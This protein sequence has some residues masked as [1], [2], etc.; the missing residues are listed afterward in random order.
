M[1]ISNG[2]GGLTTITNNGA[3]GSALDDLAI[4]VYGGGQVVM[5]NTGSVFGRVAFEAST[6]GNTFTNAG[7]I[8]GGVSLGA[9]T[10][11]RFNAVTGSQL[12]DLHGRQV[13]KVTRPEGFNIEFAEDG[14]V[15]GGL[16][17]FNTL[18]LQNAV[19]GGSGT[20]GTG[21]IAAAAYVNFQELLVESGTWTID[22]ALL[23]GAT[24]RTTL[25]GGALSVNNDNFAGSGAILATGGALTT[26]AASLILA[27]N[28][29]LGV[30]ATQGSNGLNLYGANA[31]TLDGVISGAAGAT[32][33]KN[34]SG[35]LRLNGVNSYAGGTLLNGGTTFVGN[36]SAFGSGSLTIGTG[37]A[38]VDSSGVIT[39][40]NA[41][42][43]GGSLILD[44]SHD[45]ALA[46]TISGAGAL[47]K[48]GNGNLTL[49]AANSYQGGTSLGA[50]SLTLAHDAALGTGTLSVS[51]TSSLFTTGNRQLGNAVAIASQLTFDGSYDLALNGGLSGS[52]ELVKNGNGQLLLGSASA[53]TGTTRVNAGSMI[54][55]GTFASAQVQVA[56]GADLIFQQDGYGTFAGAL[57]GTGEA[58]KRGAGT[59]LMTGHS[60]FSGNFIVQ[61]GTLEMGQAVTPMASV[62]RS[63]LLAAPVGGAL[64]ANVVV[65]SGARLSG[66]G[67][68]G[69]LVNSGTVQPG[70]NGNLTVS[71]DFTN[72]SNGTLSINLTQQPTSYL[73]VG[74]TANLGGTLNLFSLGTSPVDTSYTLLTADGG[75]I[76]TFDTL[77]VASE[78]AFITAS[79]GYG[80]NDLTLSVVRNGVALA[81]V[82]WSRN[83]VGVATALDSSAAPA[84][85]RNQV[86]GLSATSARS[87]F[88]ALSGEIHA[89]T[90][91]VLI[92]DSRYV[93]DTVNERMRQGGCPGDARSVLAPS[94]DL[95][96]SSA[97][98]QGE[99]VGWMRALGG[100]GDYDS[101]HAA[102]SVDRDL[103]GFMLGFDNNLNE[104]WRAGIAAGY[105][106][107]SIKA[108]DRGSDASVD[109]Y[110]LATYLSYQMDAFA[111]RL[112]AAY[113]WHD[114]DSKREVAVGSY[115]DRL[116]AGYKAG[117]AQVFGEVGYTLQAAGVAVEPF[118]GIAWV[119]YDSDTAREKGGDA[120]LEASAKQDVTFTTVG[121]R[122]GKQF[123]LDN[124][125]TV[126]PRGSIGWRHALGDTTPDADM[127]F[128]DGGAAFSVQ[129]APIAR[130]AAVV[131][132]GLDVGVG[133]SGKLGLGYSGQLASGNRDHAVTVSFSLGF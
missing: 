24:T 117:S 95:Q 106:N 116:K 4:A 107:S 98:C 40:G 20:S 62:A 44:G 43:L 54:V 66:N 74:G 119:N 126:T 79:L 49:N 23:S 18:A 26:S 51:G 111:A 76:G 7:R 5:V 99:G 57:S 108:N 82:A 83:Q 94:G 56:S 3:L 14:V 63:A 69:S 103:S 123:V 110:H 127:R 16:G 68:V 104:D 67:T 19:G 122:M 131:E 59:L 36:D 70:P 6:Q 58:F 78:L 9:G 72:A 97:G 64:A 129:G 55:N 15:D 133:A 118:A 112:G 85:L 1:D 46:G 124:G 105:T 12:T 25:S 39:L 37:G 101:T 114:I 73:A 77:S 121:L 88:D 75:I 47:V 31:I 92:E 17:G 22:G 130:D 2:A 48:N 61:E 11:N 41:V 8:L 71:G 21:S 34:G 132:A 27:N 53:Y 87:A 120:R 30:N 60:D 28:I 38:R 89:S 45:L 29:T 100:W 113:S 102:A 33:V 109:S 93:R 80:S 96:Q 125:T 10:A 42:V 65:N 84:S 128:V 52:G 50:G 86:T 90:A 91:S 35:V 13:G 81:D 32:L 115:N